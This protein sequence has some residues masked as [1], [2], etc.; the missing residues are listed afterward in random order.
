MPNPVFLKYNVHLNRHQAFFDED[1]YVST[2]VIKNA[3]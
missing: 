1:T 3:F 2:G